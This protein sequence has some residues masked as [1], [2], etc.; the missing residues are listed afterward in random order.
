MENQNQT[1]IR[2]YSNAGAAKLREMAENP[3]AYLDFLKFQGRVFKH[4]GCVALEFFAQKPD[5]QFIATKEQWE[6]AGCHV[7]QEGK[8][9]SFMDKNGDT[10]EF[11]DYSQV[12]GKQPHRWTIHARNAT[13]IKKAL[14]I[15]EGGSLISTAVQNSLQASQITASMAALRVPPQ[16]FRKF[17]SSFVTAVQCMIA[18]RL[19]VG[20]NQ[21]GVHPDN[22]MFRELKTDAERLGFLSL[23]ANAARGILQNMERAA[24]DLEAQRQGGFRV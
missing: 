22:T 21:F 18:G 16:E 19:E 24:L 1:P 4:S 9:I 6:R 7:T 20:G 17:S 14:G 12:A 3:S 23:V 11:Y 15:S 8:A 5:A 2:S 13:S 10:T